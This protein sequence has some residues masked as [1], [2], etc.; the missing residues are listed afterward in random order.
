MNN[1]LPL[2]WQWL[3]NNRLKAG[4]IGYVML[5]VSFAILLVSPSDFAI[6]LIFVGGVFL[7]PLVFGGPDVQEKVTTVEITDMQAAMNE[8][9]SLYKKIE[10]IRRRA[11]EIE[12]HPNGGKK[13]E[14]KQ[15]GTVV[16]YVFVKRGKYEVAGA[17]RDA[18]DML[19]VEPPSP[20]Y[21]IQNLS[22]ESAALSIFRG[23]S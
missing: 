20:V 11:G 13:L 10:D 6:F 5:T 2:F 16:A 15:R 4:G 19:K 1:P 8:F 21:Q 14:I 17:K 3:W 9:P 12:V 23:Q 7:F 22:D 18:L